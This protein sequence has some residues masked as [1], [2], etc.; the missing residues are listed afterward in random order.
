MAHLATTYLGLPLKHPVVA[1]A[2]PLS[3]SLDGIRRLEDAG[4]SA[5]VMFSLF[6]EQ[7]RQENDALE[8]FS[9][10]G[11]NSSPEASSYFPTAVDYEVGP[12]AYLELIR[13]AKEAVDVPIIGSLNGTTATGWTQYAS[14]MEQSGA[15]A[16]ELNIFH[17]PSSP[18]ANPVQV[19]QR[20][21]DVVAAVRSAVGVPIA[22]KVGPYFSAFGH[23]ATRLVHAGAG[24][25]VL[26]NR[27]Y[28]PDFDLETLKVAPTLELSQAG[29]IRL[30]LLWIALLHGRVRVSLAATTGVQSSVEVVK[31][32]LAGAD[33]VM[34]ASALLHFG[35]GHLQTLVSGLND[36][37][38]GRGV[39]S[40]AQ[41]RGS[42]SQGKVPGP[43]QFER[44]NYIKMLQSWKHPYLA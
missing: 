35:V 27:F 44:A 39:E 32:L 10:V 34:T 16:I 6:E 12:D 5:I 19:E 37:L 17:I 3:K 24:G 18:L 38:D 28:Q 43:E 30:P 42:M 31:Y 20:Y 1:S 21:T 9:G 14:M 8:H 11:L 23:M 15:D 13:K 40:V 4:A 33:V 36:W 7:I 29:E 22:V 25:L 2:S 41:V 26:F